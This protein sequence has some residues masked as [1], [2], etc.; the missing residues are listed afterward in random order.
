MTNIKGQTNVISHRFGSGAVKGIGKEFGRFI[1][2]TMDIPWRVTKD[3]IGGTPEYVYMVNSV[4]Q[5]VLDQQLHV[6]PKCDTVLGIGGGKA[7]DAAK[8][9]AWK[10]NIRLVTI[11]TII[12]VDAFVTPAAGVRINHEVA[13]VGKASPDPLVIDYDVIR[14]APSDLNL[15]GIG[16]LLSMHTACFDWEYAHSKNRS[17]YPFSSEAVKN[18]RAILQD[19]YNVVNDIR[20]VTDN[21]IR[22]LVEGNM[23]MNTIAHP[24]GHWR[25]EEGSEHFLFY[26]LEERLQRPFIHGHIVG[27]GIYLMSRLQNNQADY[28]TRIMDDVKLQYHPRSMNIKRENL[29][30]SLK[31]LNSYVQ[32]KEQLWY[33]IIDDSEISDEWINEALSELLF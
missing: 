26:E 14:T 24:A 28:I 1:V 21:G 16:D 20:N 27:L 18:A 19:L 2:A 10:R 12:S 33:T 31:N 29:V 6:L 25:F 4:E 8:Y 5:K 13:Y 32:S 22:V 17:E 15:A 3:M 9:F 11:P 30:A 23:R 7:I